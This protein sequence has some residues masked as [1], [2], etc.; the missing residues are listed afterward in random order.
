[1]GSQYWHYS[2]DGSQSWY[3]WYFGQACSDVLQV[4]EQLY[5]RVN[6]PDGLP[7]P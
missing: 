1:V 5:A 2:T 6:S 3:Y 4:M 7:S